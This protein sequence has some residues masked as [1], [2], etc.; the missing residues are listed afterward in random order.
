MFIQCKMLYWLYC[1]LFGCCRRIDRM[2]FRD[3]TKPRTTLEIEMPPPSHPWLCIYGIV[4]DDEDQ[5]EIDVTDI[6]NEHVMNGQLVDTS[7]LEAITGLDSA[8]RWEYIDSLTFDVREITSDGL[9]N[10][11]K[12]KVD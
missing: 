12:P 1:Q 8:V 2:L 9:V 4:S 6:I 11:V 10:E 7:W 5:D 3:E